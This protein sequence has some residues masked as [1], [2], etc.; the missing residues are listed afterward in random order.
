MAVALSVGFSVILGCSSWL[1]IDM[2][3]LSD[4]CLGRLWLI[5]FNRVE[6]C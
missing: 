5:A 6:T 4:I 1:K 3:E 2:P